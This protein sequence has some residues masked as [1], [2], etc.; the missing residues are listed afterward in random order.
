MSDSI[1]FDFIRHNPDVKTDSCIVWLH[2]LGASG[3][4]FAPITPLLRQAASAPGLA[5]I[6]PHAPELAV[7][8]NGGM[9]MPAWYDILAASPRRVINPY[10]FQQSVT[11]V[12]NLIS[13]LIAEGMSSRRILVAGFSQG[14]AV[15]YQAALGFGQPLGG[16][17]CLSTYL[18]QE[19]LIDK[20]NKRLPVFIGHGQMDMVVPQMLGLEA[21][22]LLEGQ[23]L[24]PVWREYPIQH[25]VSEQQLE[26]VATFIRR[27]LT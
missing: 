11:A 22:S 3:Y 13:D 12:Q 10:Q 5:A 14:G 9:K 24:T 1:T 25:E 27:V 6:Y 16:L 23:E 26:D 8:I 15:A 19:P 21:M 20:E 17:V 18:A 4:D 7:T 2:G